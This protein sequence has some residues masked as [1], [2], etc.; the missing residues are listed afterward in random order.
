MN[1]SMLAE[2]SVQSE[3]R[4]RVV[5]PQHIADRVV[6]VN[7][8]GGCGK[9]LVA[10]IVGSLASVELMKYDY[11]LEHACMLH[12]LNVLDAETAAALVRNYTDLDLYHLM[13]SRETNFRPSD[14]SGVT[15]NARPWRYVRRLFLPEGEE[16]V[17]RVRRER[18]ILHLVTHHLLG[19]SGPLFDGL[20][21]RVRFIEVVRHPLYMVKQ[22][23]QWMPRVD[24]D[25]R[26]FLLRYEY[27]GQPLPW[28][29]RGWEEQYLRSGL[30][31]RVIYG[32]E[33]QLAL[34]EQRRQDL[35]D[36][37]RRQVMIIPFEQFVTH[38]GPFLQQLELFLGSRVTP[39]TRR[40]MKKQRVPRKMYAEGIGLPIYKSYGWRPPAKGADEQREFEARRRYA[41]ELASPEAMTVLDR[42]SAA[43]EATYLHDGMAGRCERSR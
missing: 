17:D 43:Y 1:P 34:G 25:P 33:H 8:L 19:I 30:M 13:M 35:S 26:V 42:L 37:Q 11:Q 14:L 39:A 7:G 27:K 6:I 20:G 40:M 9:T 12:Y 2:A 16:A 24:A 4:M 3:T 5:R 31:D 15:M 32:L 21:E 22:W 23:Y 18:P 10:P 41:A 38:P 28:F 29:V 36:R